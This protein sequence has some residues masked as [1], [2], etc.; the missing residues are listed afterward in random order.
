MLLDALSSEH[1]A[2]SQLHRDRDVLERLSQAV[3]EFTV[4]MQRA[5]LPEDVSEHLPVALRIARYYLEGATLAVNIATVQEGLDYIQDPRLNDAVGRFR[6]ECASLLALSDPMKE[7]Y[8]SEAV[9]LALGE[10]ESHYQKL[11][12]QLLHAGSDGHIRM[13]EMVGQLNLYSEV[14]RAMEQSVKGA[15]YLRGLAEW[16]SH[17][18]KQEEPTPPVNNSPP[19]PPND[20]QA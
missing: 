6:G 17:F 18:Q 9:Q 15:N 14:R 13:P 16:V 11:K 3:N 8:S 20:E 2:G 4:E 5:H 1:H 19:V 7:G 12:T 10:L